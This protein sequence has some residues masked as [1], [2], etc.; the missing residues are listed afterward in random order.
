MAVFMSYYTLF[1]RFGGIYNDPKTRYMIESYDQN[2]I[3]FAFYGR[4][5]ELLPTVFRLQGDLQ[6]P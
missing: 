3:V 6:Q 1:W 4:F 2:L 5:H